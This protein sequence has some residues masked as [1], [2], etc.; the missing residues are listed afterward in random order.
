LQEARQYWRKSTKRAFG[1]EVSTFLGVIKCEGKDGCFQKKQ[2]RKN[3]RKGIK[4]KKFQPGKK[5]RGKKRK[6]SFLGGLKLF[7]KA[8]IR[9]Y[10]SLE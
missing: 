4:A 6:G 1:S 10:S 7:H 3:K 9:G 2:R 8:D 5:E